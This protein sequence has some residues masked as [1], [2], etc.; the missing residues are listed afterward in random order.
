LLAIAYF[1][2]W[3]AIV[4]MPVLAGC[5]IGGG[6]TLIVG[7][8]HCRNR[9]LAA[10]VGVLAAVISYVGYYEC[11]FLHDAPPQFAG[12]IDLLPRYIAL[13]MK[14]DVAEDVGRAVDQKKPRDSNVYLNWFTSSFELLCVV[15]ICVAFAWNRARRAYCQELEQWMR[16]EKAILPSNAWRAILAA[17]E[18]GQLE[19]FVANTPKGSDAQTACHLV[20]EYVE[21]HSGFVLDYPVYASVEAL[22]EPGSARMFQ[23]I[24]RTQLRQ[25]KLEVAEVLIL[26]PLFPKLAQRL[27]EQ[28]AE[29]RDLPLEVPI[30]P[31]T[32][33]PATELAQVTPVPER[34]RQTVRT[35]WYPLWVNL[36]GLTPM[37]Y[38]FG[39]IGLIGGG[40][41]L[42]T[43]KAM[44]LGWAMIPVGAV[45]F[46]WGVY[47]G[48]YCLCVAENRWI[49]RRLRAEIGRRPD[50]LVDP[51]D[52]ASIYVSLI[53][54]EHFA[55]VRLTMSSD[56]LLLK[57]DEPQR[58]LV[59]EGDCDR[60]R[61]PGGA[62]TTCEPECFYH[63]MD[64]H[65]SKQL[66]MVRLMV[67]FEEGPREMLF[68]AD[69]TQWRPM[70]NAR[71]LEKAKNL[72]EQINALKPISSES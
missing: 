53:P 25:A 70:T 30:A 11:C 34:Y 50:Y 67:Q 22:P 72:C 19:K 27:A 49:E 2:G 24:R 17:L 5:L 44:P 61:I 52:P 56:L 29:L 37:V 42:V 63:A 38:F 64:A 65:R 20:L 12:R 59:M 60:Y 6:L 51:R 26:R 3:Y 36:I 1:S 57:I 47:T 10:G 45:G 16:R 68:C 33:V 15:G 32:E 46:A 4:L 31:S 18:A 40:A 66:W 69:A 14:T 7:W 41:W 39:G 21:P 23:K 48:L 54:R 35:R 55:K 9:W 13:R 62:I 28:H 8:A 58:L 43:E 71:R